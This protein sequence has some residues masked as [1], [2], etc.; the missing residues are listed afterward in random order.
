[1]REAMDGSM[2]GLTMVGLRGGMMTSTPA[3]C[4]CPGLKSQRWCSWGW[5]Q[6]LS[7]AVLLLGQRGPR[8]D[9]VSMMWSERRRRMD[10]IAAP[11][12]SQKASLSAQLAAS[13]GGLRKA[14][15]LSGSVAH[16]QASP[17]IMDRPTSTTGPTGHTYDGA[18]LARGSR[19]RERKE[20]R[21]WREC[22]L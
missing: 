15:A 4:S 17:F 6:A 7:G 11:A 14:A 16:R 22:S 19:R 3:K 12:S 21:R 8:H 5:D 1:M 13:S 10:R 2:D 18:R 9:H 20:G